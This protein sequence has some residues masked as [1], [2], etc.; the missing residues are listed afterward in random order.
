MKA[1]VLFAFLV[2]LAPTHSPGFLLTQAIIEGIE[3]YCLI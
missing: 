3:F 2:P 1:I